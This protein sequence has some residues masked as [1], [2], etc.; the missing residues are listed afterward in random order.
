MKQKVDGLMRSRWLRENGFSVGL[1]LLVTVFTSARFMGDTIDYARSIVWYD[2]NRYY[3]FW[4]FGHLLWRPLGWV[5]VRTSF[6]LT[7]LIVGKDP[8]ANTT[9][10]LLVINWLAGL[11]G[12]VSLAALLRLI[13]R[14]SWSINIATTS[15]IVSYAFLNFL[16]SGA[17]YIPG[18]SCLLIALY[19]NVRMEI[20]AEKT[21]PWATLVAV[22]L[23]AAVCLWLPFVL[24]VPAVLVAPLAFTHNS[25]RSVRLIIYT[26][27]ISGI[28]V[29]S[30]YLAVVVGALGIHTIAGLRLWMQHTVGPS[31]HNLPRTVFGLARSCIYMGEDGMLVKRYLIH[32]PFNPVTAL[33]LFRLSIWKLFAFYV[34]LASILINLLLSKQGKKMLALFLLN[35]VPVV[36]FAIY[37]QGGDPER[38][39]PL[40]PLMFVALGFSLERHPGSR[41]LFKYFVFCFVLI[42]A[43]TNIHSLTT[44]VLDRQQESAAVRVR[45]LVPLLKPNSV[46]FTAN[47]QDD[48]VNF[49]RSFPFNPINRQSNL[50]ITAVI[51]PGDADI[52]RWREVF[53]ERALSVWKQGGDVWLSNRSRSQRP[54]SDWNWVEGDDRRVSW[55]DIYRFFAQLEMGQSVGGEDGFMLLLPSPE[56]KQRLDQL[57]KVSSGNLK[58][59]PESQ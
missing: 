46:V 24:A 56:N 18:L 3:E 7:S 31:E 28:I 34:F 17:P 51:T 57:N 27:F 49:N 50:L 33:E 21:T 5:L 40:Y 48:L 47:W 25:R 11:I 22:C 45:S 52:T 44:L 41:A 6:P 16:H 4:E 32:D 1:Y 30:V 37:W 15:F 9:V 29:A 38:Y 36:A 58:I 13:C 42:A 20:R 10:I 54:K 8:Q 12:V 23:A 53:A 19:I 59:S 35:A 14:S 55:T 26:A 39:L 43:V 2:R